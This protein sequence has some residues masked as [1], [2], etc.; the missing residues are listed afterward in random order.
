VARLS[1][2]QPVTEHNKI[3]LKHL[4]TNNLK[5]AGYVCFTLAQLL[6]V[7]IAVKYLTPSILTIQAH[8]VFN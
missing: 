8:I 1:I 2:N 5:Q 7:C 6:I 4:I 3:S